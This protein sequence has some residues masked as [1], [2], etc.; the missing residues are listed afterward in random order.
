MRLLGRTIAFRAQ[1]TD[2]RAVP[3]RRHHWRLRRLASA[4]LAAGALAA[5]LHVLAPSPPDGQPVLLAARDLAAGTALTAGD[6]RTDSRP[7]DD[8]PSGTLSSAQTVIGRV[9]TSG[10]RRGEV[11]TDARIVG[12]GLTVG[13]PPGTV[14]IPVR[15]ADRAVV[16]LVAPGD[17]VDV[18]VATDAAEATLVARSAVVLARPSP[19]GGGLL[20]TSTGTGGGLLVLAASPD[21]ASSL[22]SAAA[23][24]P[25]S[26]ALRRS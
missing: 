14:A 16:P 7:V 17:H 21:D 23:R 8:L 24:G 25:L 19:G 1:G 12:P 11:L 10:V 22:V 20:G 15:I 6:L 3:L 5:S 2:R 26:L 4:G 13:L 9:L 18:L